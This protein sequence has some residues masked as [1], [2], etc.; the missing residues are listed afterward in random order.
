[1]IRNRIASAEQPAGRPLIPSS[2]QLRVRL[3][4]IT[5][6]LP[7]LILLSIALYGEYCSAR[8]LQGNGHPGLLAGAANRIAVVATLALLWM[9]IVL[10]ITIRTVE[11]RVLRPLRHLTSVALHLAEGELDSRVEMSRIRMID[12]RRLAATVNVMAEIL[13]KLALTDSLT[14]VANRRQFDAAIAGEVKRSTR[15]KKGLAL[16]IVDVD[17]FKD[18]NDLYGHGQ[19]DQCLRRVAAALMGTVNRPG[20]LVARYGG[21]EFVVLLPNTDAAG[22]H[23]IAMDIVAAV[24]GL[25]ITH[26]A[27]ERGIVTV[28]IGLAVSVPQPGVNAGALIERADQALYAAKQAG[29]DRAIMSEIMTYA[30]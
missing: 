8:L 30:A 6:M 5:I 4:I 16:L 19:G 7:F 27:W 22:A 25:G 18:Y 3:A 9:A 10:L 12:M 28:S 2:V 13:E 20:D 23:A 24:R 11:N 15:M 17:K 26:A 21:E 1:M 14:S 29:R